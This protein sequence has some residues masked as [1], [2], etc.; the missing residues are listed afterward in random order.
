M[1]EHKSPKQTDSDA[2]EDKESIKEENIGEV[3]HDEPVTAK[4]IVRSLFMANEP[5]QRM[6]VD[7]SND[8]KPKE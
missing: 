2:A 8:Q 1:N 7:E 4:G 3:R 6:D 5:G